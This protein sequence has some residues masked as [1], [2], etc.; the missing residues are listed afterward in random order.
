MSLLNLYQTLA[1]YT[2]VLGPALIVLFVIVLKARGVIKSKLPLIVTLVV[3]I[4]YYVLCGLGFILAMRY[5]D[6]PM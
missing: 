2:I 4:A 3:V 5:L 1:V 6:L